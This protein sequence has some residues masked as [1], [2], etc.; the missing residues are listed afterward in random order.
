MGT[1]VILRRGAWGASEE[2]EAAAD[3]STKVG[4]EGR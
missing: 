4:D 3:R 1:Y 2:L